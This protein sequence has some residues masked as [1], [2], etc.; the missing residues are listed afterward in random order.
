M[1]KNHIC[2]CEQCG[3]KTKEKNKKCPICS[4]VMDEI[5][6]KI[7]ELNPTLPEKFDNSQHDHVE[8]GYYCFKCRKKV[9]KKVCLEC[10]NVA[11]MYIEVN[12]KTAI[13]KR[14]H[15]L[16]DY[17]NDEEMNL[18]RQDLNDQEKQYIYHN[19]ESAYRFFYKKDNVKFV[20]CIIIAIL[21]FIT[22]LD[23]AFNMHDREIDFMSYLFNSVANSLFLILVLLGFW[24]RFDATSIEFNKIPA[25]TGVIVCIPTL[26]QF[27][28]C[29]VKGV[30]MKEMLITGYISMGI[31]L[32]L[33]IIYFL[34]EKKHEK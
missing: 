29:L 9:L 1:K 31:A 7:E 22:F 30:E 28:Y 26:F 14:I 13:V 6:A 4:A 20:T 3:F 21:L 2:K 17:F 18:I 12:K 24:Y 19:Y 16:T 27:S 23:M 8:L 32:V 25:K 11:S 10:N 34:W 15:H 5:E 33:Y